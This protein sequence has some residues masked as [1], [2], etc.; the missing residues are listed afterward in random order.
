MVRARILTGDE[1]R[2]R[3]IEIFERHR[4][5][6]DADRLR[7]RRA[8]RLVAHVRAIGKVVRAELPNEELV[9]K[10]C[11]VGSPPGSIKNGLVRRIERAQLAADEREGVLPGDRLVM[12]GAAA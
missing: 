11:L 7:Q 12:R 10:G 8:A 6:T 9:E 2:L 5:L 3:A 1:D 4:A